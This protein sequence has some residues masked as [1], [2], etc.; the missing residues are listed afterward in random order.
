MIEELKRRPHLKLLSEEG[1]PHCLFQCQ[2]GTKKTIFAQNV[3]RGV[4][5][6]CGCFGRPVDR[7]GR[8]FCECCSLWKDL[9]AYRARAESRGGRDRVCIACVL[10]KGAARRLQYKTEYV[11]AADS[12]SKICA[13]CNVKK[14]A[15]EFH[16]S[17]SSKVG[18]RSRCKLCQR[19]DNLYNKYG[20]SREEF[21]AL[22]VRQSNKCGICQVS[23]CDKNARQVHVDHDHRD[24]RIRGILC[25]SCN[26]GLGLFKDEPDMLLRAVAYLN[27]STSPV[28]SRGAVGCAYKKRQPVPPP[29]ATATNVIPFPSRRT[30][31]APS[32]QLTLWAEPGKKVGA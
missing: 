9:A 24:G 29:T 16:P 22:L 28:S 10:K 32:K 18:L 25:Y 7:D 4:T 31:S 26:Y 21:D 23:L 27:D 14:D 1:W 17:K 6:S 11:P 8:R 2:C 5:N 19:M 20:L 3:Y 30:A 12:F 13:G 15:S